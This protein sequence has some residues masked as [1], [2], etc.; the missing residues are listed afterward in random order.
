MLRQGLTSSGLPDPSTVAT[1]ITHPHPGIAPTILGKRHRDSTTSEAG[2]DQKDKQATADSLEGEAKPARKRAKVSQQDDEHLAMESLSEASSDGV[3]VAEGLP[4]EDSESALRVPSF[5]VFSGLDEPPIEF[6]DPP[7]PTE[8]LPEFFPP[9]SPP[10]GLEVANFQRPGLTT[11]S[12]ANAAENQPFA[13]SFQPMSST[14]AHGMYMPSFPYPEPPQSPSPAGSNPVGLQHQPGRSDVFQV[15]GFPPPGRPMRTTGLRH[16]SAFGDGF[17]NPAALTHPSDHEQTRQA[18][19][20]GARNGEEPTAQPADAGS[21]V[22]VGAAEAPQFKRTMYGTELDGDTRFGDFGLEGVG[23][24]K[25]NFWAG[26]R[27]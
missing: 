17:I 11:T 13:F 14:P 16:N 10:P 7:P 6:M 25:G 12:T 4:I 2:D 18:S 1:N 20:S 26:G 21:S 15:F 19:G 24:N 27:F 5:T 23:N 22:P 9:P 3:M 8:H